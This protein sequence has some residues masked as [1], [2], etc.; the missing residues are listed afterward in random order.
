MIGQCKSLLQKR[1]SATGDQ[2]IFDIG[3]RAWKGSKELTVNVE[4]FVINIHYHFCR[5]AKQK[6]TA[7]KVHKL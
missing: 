1:R 6:K 2:K 4:D 3:C 7:N 5:S